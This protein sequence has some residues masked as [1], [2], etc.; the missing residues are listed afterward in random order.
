MNLRKP[1]IDRCGALWNSQLMATTIQ[2]DEDLLREAQQ[3]GNHPSGQAAVEDALREYIQR[4]R[5]S[6]I[7]QLFGQIDYAE[8][9]DYKAARRRK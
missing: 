5:Q 4:R 3:L 7:I 6:S 1:G 2:L 9:Y 8:D